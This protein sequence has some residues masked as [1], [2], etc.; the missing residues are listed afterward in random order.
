MVIR[1]SR[2]FGSTPETWPGVQMAYDL[3]QAHVRTVEINVDRLETAWS[4]E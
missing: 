2:V 1:L 4:S 3:W